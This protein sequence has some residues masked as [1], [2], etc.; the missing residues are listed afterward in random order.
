MASRR[1]ALHLFFLLLGIALGGGL[2][3]FL[4]WRTGWTEFTGALI[5]F[6]L[7]PLLGFIGISLL[8][9]CLYT[10]RWKIILDDMV[11]KELRVPFLRLFAHR[12]S[13][14]AAGYLTPAA[15]VAG[16]PVRVAMLRGDGV[17]LKEA[18]S[19][20]VLDLAFEITSFVM[21]VIAG[22]IL[23]F[24]QGLG[25]DGNLLWPLLFVIVLLAFLLAFFIFTV[26]GAGF[27]HRMIGLT[28]LRRF[29]PM[30]NFEKWLAETEGLMS[31][32]FA[33]KI[34]VILFIVF[35]SFTMT[36]F[37][38]VEVT[39]IAHF[40][41]VTLEL[42][43]AFLMSTL[44]G[45]ALLLP[46][47]GGLGVFEGSNAAMFALLGLSMNA[48]AFTMIVRAR[49]FLF[50]AWGVMHAVRSGEKIIPTQK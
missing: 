5:G 48:I 23:A 30:A 19:S 8:N 50:I 16:E 6:G 25:A 4:I 21:Y 3:V 37:K 15:Q 13:G 20:V 12:M 14:Y 22:I 45:V 2:L 36:A 40:F 31:R 7:L 49:D 35:L 32:F 28:G 10:L 11:K 44:P 24:A 34:G 17:P 18:T 41:G 47:P 27:F 38:A 39:Y 33:G 43:D 29:K 1:R 26:S 42:R 46:V 9:F